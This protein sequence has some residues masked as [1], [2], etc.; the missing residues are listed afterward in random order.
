MRR[1]RSQ[2]ACSPHDDSCPKRWSGI[3]PLGGGSAQRLKAD[4][5]I[6]QGGSPQQTAPVDP[7]PAHVDAC[8]GGRDLERAP[9]PPLHERESDRPRPRARSPE[10]AEVL[11]RLASNVSRRRRL[12][13][14]SPLCRVRFPRLATDDPRVSVPYSQCR[15]S[16]GFFPLSFPISPPGGGRNDE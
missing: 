13:S 3:D 15:T 4:F 16:V 10:P 14:A 9:P 8:S 5:E 7:R 11:A 1:R 12:R 2:R 6:P